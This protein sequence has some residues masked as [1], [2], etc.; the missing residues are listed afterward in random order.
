MIGS[1]CG[2]RIT[3]SA[4]SPVVDAFPAFL[5]V[6]GVPLALFALSPRFPLKFSLEFD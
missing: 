1:G 4:G 6:R 2:G 3:T 5:Y